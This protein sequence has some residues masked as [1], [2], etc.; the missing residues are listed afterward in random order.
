MKLNSCSLHIDAIVCF[1]GF[2]CPLCL[3]IESG[4]YLDD[5]RDELRRET[6]S[7]KTANSFLE[8]DLNEAKS[9]IDS[10]EETIKDLDKQL[11]KK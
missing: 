4:K 11:N 10:L 9:K 3:E 1:Q 2:D 7:L 8:R 5:E 6:E